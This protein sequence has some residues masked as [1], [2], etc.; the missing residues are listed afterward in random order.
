MTLRKSHRG[1]PQILGT[2]TKNKTAPNLC[3]HDVEEITTRSNLSDRP[4]NLKVAQRRHVCKN[5]NIFKAC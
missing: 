2:T 1:P 5:A 3:V 4:Y